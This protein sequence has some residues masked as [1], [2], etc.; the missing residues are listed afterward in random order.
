MSRLLSSVSTS[1]VKVSRGLKGAARSAALFGRAIADSLIGRNREFFDLTEERT[2]RRDYELQRA[3]V[4]NDSI[5][6]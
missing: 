4:V 5:N 2:F 3:R 6:L 1:F